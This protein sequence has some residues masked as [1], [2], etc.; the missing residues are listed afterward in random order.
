MVMMRTLVAMRGGA[1]GAGRSAQPQTSVRAAAVRT[2]TQAAIEDQGFMKCFIASVVRN[3]VSSLAES[4]KRCLAPFRE[5]C[6]APFVPNRAFRP[7]NCCLFLRISRDPCKK[8]AGTFAG[9]VPA[10]FV[11]SRGLFT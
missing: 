9:K 5:K 4:R 11:T 1:A 6:Q 8:V 10:T 2:L 7:K 3:P